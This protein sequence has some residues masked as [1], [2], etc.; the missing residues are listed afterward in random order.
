MQPIDFFRVY[1]LSYASMVLGNGLVYFLSDKGVTTVVKPETELEIVARNELGQNTYASPA[2][3]DG[4]M[5]LRGI[6]NLYCISTEK[7]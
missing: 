5:F 7:Y 3:S 6:K 2:I 1:A 4:Q